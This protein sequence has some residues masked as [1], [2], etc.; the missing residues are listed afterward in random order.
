M[1]DLCKQKRIILSSTWTLMSCQWIKSAK[2]FQNGSKK[3]WKTKAAQWNLNF[4]SPSSETLWLQPRVIRR[5]NLNY[6]HKLKRRS[7]LIKSMMWEIFSCWSTVKIFCRMISSFHMS[8]LMIDFPSLYPTRFG[9]L[10]QHRDW[11]LMKRLSLVCP[12]RQ[13]KSRACWRSWTR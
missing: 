12:A 13:C 11:R 10:R 2:E 9:S 8:R 7:L 1:I 4:T 6:C 5:Y 3:R